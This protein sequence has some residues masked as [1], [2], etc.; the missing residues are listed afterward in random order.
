MR[1][2][3]PP[4]ANSALWAGTILL[5]AAVLGLPVAVMVY[6]RTPY[7]TD[8]L[9]EVEQPVQFDHRHHVMDD[10]IDCLYC[11]YLADRSPWA[12]VPPTELCMNCH[13]QIWNDAPLLEPVRESF[14]S[15]RPIKWLRVNGVPDFVFFNHAVHVHRGVGCATCH[16]RVDQMAAVHA[17]AP[18]QM[19]WCLECH[20]KPERFLRP[21]D[22]ITDMEWQLPPDQQL[23]LGRELKEKLSIIPPTSCTGCHR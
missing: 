9:K 23:L 3:F 21:L 4:W 15:G 22:K 7:V 5:L 18:L 10:G 14:F 11:H 1:P 8:R 13:A 19:Q 20:R 6:M 2:L 17:A 16:G 12:G